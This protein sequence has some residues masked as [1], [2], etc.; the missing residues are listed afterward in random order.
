MT[1]DM[2]P[3]P[4]DRRGTLGIDACGGWQIRFERRVRH[5]PELVL[6]HTWLWPG[7]PPS[8]VRWEIAAEGSGSVVVLWHRPVSSGPAV[9]YATG[10]HVMLDALALHLDGDRP[11]DH[12]PDF[13]G[14]YEEY[15]SGQRHVRAVARAGRATDR[16]SPG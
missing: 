15:R 16:P 12:E 9:D 5:V 1:D 6:E 11:A 3:A 14:L 13:A 7:E 2:A 8:T 10:W 4:D